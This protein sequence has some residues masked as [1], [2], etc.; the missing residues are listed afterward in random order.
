MWEYAGVSFPFC[1][2]YIYTLPYD[3]VTK[4]L[5]AVWYEHQHVVKL[6]SYI[7]KIEKI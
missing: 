7:I 3:G 2:I 5:G 6:T 1:G 4:T